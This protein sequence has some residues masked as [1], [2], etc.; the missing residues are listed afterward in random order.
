MKNSSHKIDRDYFNYDG[1]SK[2]YKIDVN[3]Q[4]STAPLIV[5]SFG[6]TNEDPNYQI[7]RNNSKIFILEYVEKGQ[8]SLIN[9]GKNY[10][11]N[12]N[13]TYL[14]EPGSTHKYSSNPNNPIK[15]Y[16]INFN[17][18]Y[19][20]ALLDSFNLVNITHFP[21]V[22]IKS[23]FEELLSLYK[24][25]ELFN[26]EIYEKISL[27]LMKIILKLEKSIKNKDSDN[28]LVDRIC[29]FIRLN[30]LSKFTYNDLIKEF[31]ISKENMLKLFQSSLNMT[32]FDY[33]HLEKIRLIKQMLYGNNY[34]IKNISIMLSF[35]SEYHMSSFFK[36]YTGLSP[37]EFKKINGVKK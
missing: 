17:T 25:K 24:G 31:G 30:I 5:Y 26:D 28:D 33:I 20:F 4:N 6:I 35:S 29:N 23:E 8:I 37:S 19:F 9:N 21:Q 11:I 34:T 14:L 18:E 12:K 15:K 16:W 27:I 1:T 7:S 2:E 36:K 13:D 3:Y 32:P 10:L 22:N